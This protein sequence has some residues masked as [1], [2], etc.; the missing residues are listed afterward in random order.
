MKQTIRISIFLIIALCA[1]LQP[2]LAQQIRQKTVGFTLSHTLK[3][4]KGTCQKVE[5]QELSIKQEGQTYTSNAF[6]VIVPLEGM[7][8][9]NQNRDSNMLEILGYPGT[10]EVIARINPV[11]A[12]PGKNR[13]RGTILLNGQEKPFESEFE[14]TKSESGVTITGTARLRLSDFS[15]APPRLLLFSIDDEIEIAYNVQF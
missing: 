4:V 6:R 10:K 1:S 14:L 7:T 15:I 9:G 8:T 2:L 3:S 12:Q 11:T 13:L 5:L